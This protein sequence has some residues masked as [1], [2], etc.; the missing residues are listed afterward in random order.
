MVKYS[1][2]VLVIGPYPPPIGGVSESVRKLTEVLKFS[3]KNVSI[4]NT[5]SGK[6]R[7]DLYSRKGFKSYF[8]G[9]FLLINF[10]LAVKKN[11]P[12]E[13]HLF[14][15]SNSAF[16]RDLFFI[17]ILKLFSVRFYTHLH[18]KKTGEM[19]LGSFGIRFLFFFLKF[20]EVIF[21]LSKDHKL[22]F[23]GYTRAKLVVLENFCMSNEFDASVGPSNS[24]LYCGRVSERKGFYDLVQALIAIKAD[25]DF[26][27]NIL[28]VCDNNKTESLVE[29]MTRDL[30]DRI[31]F[32]GNTFG[33][34]KKAFFRKCGC[35]IFP[36]QFENSP[37]VLK[38]A[39]MAGLLIVASDIE[40]NKNV[41]R[42]YPGAFYFKAGDYVYLS[43]VIKKVIL[44]DQEKTSFLREACSNF[45]KFDESYAISVLNK[46]RF[47]GIR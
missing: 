39:M 20:S 8:Y 45:R 37:V 36:S 2:E 25:Q 1:R 28:G 3:G 30:K 27:I 32:N 13:C 35:F 4:F 24:F 19:F 12:D 18:S 42:N 17:L 15:T 26:N 47:D 23:S 10:F 22:F 44:M 16:L 6:S 33:E 46:V 21:V 5:S 34:E 43:L 31:V 40:A 7:E 9:L 11:K 14:V 29:L 41:L 38:E